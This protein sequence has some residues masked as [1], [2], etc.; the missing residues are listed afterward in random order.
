MFLVPWR[1]TICDCGDGLDV[2]LIRVIPRVRMLPMSRLPAMN[3]GVV[4]LVVKGELNRDIY[5]T[6][7]SL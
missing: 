7:K 1:V 2:F 3:A 6:F 4:S 5:L